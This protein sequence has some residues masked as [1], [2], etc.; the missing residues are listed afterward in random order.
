MAE[1][2]GG[3]ISRQS[4]LAE[5]RDTFEAQLK[6][7][8]A[9]GHPKISRTGVDLYP[10]EISD[11]E[12]VL[13]NPDT[14]SESSRIIALGRAEVRTLQEKYVELESRALDGLAA[15]LGKTPEEITAVIN[16]VNNAAEKSIGN[17][18]VAGV[19][20]RELGLELD[21]VRRALSQHGF[22]ANEARL[23]PPPGFEGPWDGLTST[24]GVTFNPTDSQLG[25]N[26]E[27][28]EEGRRTNWDLRFPIMGIAPPS[29]HPQ[30][31][32]APNGPHDTAKFDESSTPSVHPQEQTLNGPRGSG[33]QARTSWLGV[34]PTVTPG[35]F[36][37]LKGDGAAM[38]LQDG[39]VDRASHHPFA[40]LD[41]K[42]DAE[43]ITTNLKFTFSPVGQDTSPIGNRGVQAA[44]GVD[45]GGASLA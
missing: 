16:R 45:K 7:K 36:A 39:A 30:P 33:G 28:I 34:K 24:P 9:V 37:H 23:G 40:A 6:K 41:S 21:A 38:A 26:R 4:G 44:M 11:S 17:M 22:S 35:E 8:Q 15:T 10:Y 31:N 27:L 18:D 29:V 14:P 43:G 3:E 5:F 2:G 1:G 42:L 32:H 20:A 19:V 12:E 25:I 13:R